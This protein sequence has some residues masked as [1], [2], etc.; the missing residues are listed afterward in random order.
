MKGADN[1]WADIQ[2]KNGWIDINPQSTSGIPVGGLNLYGNKCSIIHR[3]LNVIT[4]SGTNPVSVVNNANNMIVLT[5][6]GSR[7]KIWLEINHSIG[8]WYIIMSS[9][10]KGYDIL[11]SS[12]REKFIRD[13]SRYSALQCDG[14]N[15]TFVIKVDNS[16]WMG[17]SMPNYEISYWNG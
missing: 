16:N 8:A 15:A 1:S 13:G 10:S 17:Y 5:G 3:G 2:I 9:S 7:K 6:E 12:S 4:L 11:L 14:D